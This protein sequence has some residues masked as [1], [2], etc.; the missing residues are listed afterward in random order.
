[1]SL[2][3][4]YS[5]Y[6]QPSR[7]ILTFLLLTSIPHEIKI[8]EL[9]K[10]Q[11]RS[12][13]YLKIN[14]LGKVPALCDDDFLLSESE[15]IILYII[16]SR[17]VGQE[18]YPE[19]PKLRALVNQYFPYHH[20]H[21]RPRLIN[22]FSLV[23]FPYKIEGR[24]DNVR[25]EALEV[26]KQFERVFLNENKKYIVGDVFTIADIFAANEF[27]QV[28]YGIPDFD[29]SNFPVL[30]AYVERCLENKVLCDVNKEMK[31]FPKLVKRLK[32]EA[33]GERD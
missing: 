1:M 25:F 5:P 3:L 12:P 27:L 30:K 21:V 16:D 23:W 13:E 22:L 33:L 6:S 10:G 17:N 14:P 4:Y 15:A 29:W 9:L 26:C 8:I 19:D 11:Q 28:Y 7:A 2:T 24:K 18:Y 32:E 31:E 20:A